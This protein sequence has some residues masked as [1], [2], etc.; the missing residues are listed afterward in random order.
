MT[1]RESLPSPPSE[2]TKRSGKILK[3]IGWVVAALVVLYIVLLIPFGEQV[4]APQ[5]GE[6][7]QK[8]P[9]AWNQDEY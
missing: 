7:M 5:E 1:A 2:V 8:L 4:N 3:R 6:R 9:F